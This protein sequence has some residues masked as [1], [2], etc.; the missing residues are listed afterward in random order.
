MTAVFGDK[1]RLRTEIGDF[2]APNYCI[3]KRDQRRLTLCDRS[4]VDRYF[5][6]WNG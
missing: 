2:Y 1:F 5:L 4:G 6:E 3:F